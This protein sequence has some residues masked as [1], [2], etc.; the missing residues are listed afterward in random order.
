MSGYNQGRSKSVY[1]VGVYVASF[2][3]FQLWAVY[4][5]IRPDWVIGGLILLVSLYLFAVRGLKKLNKV[6]YSV[7]AFIGVCTLSSLSLFNESYIAWD[8]FYTIYVQIIFQIAIFFSIVNLRLSIRDITKVMNIWYVI[9]VIVSVYA[10]YQIP[11]RIVGLPY[12]NILYGEVLGPGL[13]ETK[14]FARMRANSIFEEPDDLGGYL[15]PPLIWGIVSINSD[16]YDL[17]PFRSILYEMTTLLIVS[18]A[19]LFTFSQATYFVVAAII[20]LSISLHNKNISY[21]GIVKVFL[22]ICIVVTV[23]MS[24]LSVEYIAW[25]SNRLLA[26]SQLRVGEAGSLRVRLESWANI[27]ETWRQNPLLGTGIGVYESGTVARSIG[28]NTM[29]GKLLVSTGLFG[30][31]AFLLLAY[32]SI[33]ALYLLS[34]KCVAIISV[35]ASA[36]MLMIA[37]EFIRGVGSSSYLSPRIWL[38]L[39]LASSLYNSASR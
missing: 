32:Q 12:D 3:L 35:I 29:I 10:I 6:D 22:P 18:A 5:I 9:A 27:I 38:L 21:V 34:S 16:K 25:F 15:V 13:S 31:V 2:P 24:F 30:L 11:A 4:G 36:F 26:T 1:I 28:V 33:R 37:G 8:Q 17:L 19:L 20:L 14:E 39:A 23:V 7:L